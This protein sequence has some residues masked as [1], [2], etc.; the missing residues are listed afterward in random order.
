M[1]PYAHIEDAYLFQ[2]WGSDV[3]Y[4]IKWELA[5]KDEHGQRHWVNH[6]M[7]FSP[8]QARK[9]HEVLGFMLNTE[10]EERSTIHWV[11]NDGDLEERY[12]VINA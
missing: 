10:I 3:Q 8:E 7:S 9:L 12:Q 4:S 2:G 5:L 6:A 11:V 1:S